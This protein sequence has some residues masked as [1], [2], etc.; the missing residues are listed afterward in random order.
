MGNFA[1]C[2]LVPFR[3]LYCH[4][5]EKLPGTNEDA[6]PHND[7]HHAPLAVSCLFLSPLNTHKH[8]E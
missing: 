3:L 4:T 7:H 6:I 5:H 8:V 1:Y 2:A